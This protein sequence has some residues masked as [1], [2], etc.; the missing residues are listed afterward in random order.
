[1]KKSVLALLAP[2]ALVA[3]SLTACTG[4]SPS[5]NKVPTVEES[6]ASCTVVQ[7]TLENIIAVGPETTDFDQYKKL[8]DIPKGE[9]EIP[10]VQSA[11]DKFTSSNLKITSIGAKAFDEGRE[12]TEDEWTKIKDVSAEGKE[13]ME[14]LAY[15]CPAMSELLYGAAQS[16]NQSGE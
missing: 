1:M 11:W 7:E 12:L 14:Q 9:I 15:Y 6:A 3:I 2:I 16:G 8:F 5:A 13:G 4:S 10:E